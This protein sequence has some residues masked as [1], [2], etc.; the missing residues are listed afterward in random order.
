MSDDTRKDSEYDKTAGERLPEQRPHSIEKNKDEA[1]AQ[2]I[3]R[4]ITTSSNMNTRRRGV[5]ALFEHR[6]RDVWTYTPCTC[7]RSGCSGGCDVLA[8]KRLPKQRPQ[9]EEHPE[10]KIEVHLGAQFPHQDEEAGSIVFQSS[11]N[12]S[13]IKNDN[14]EARVMASAA[15]KVSEDLSNKDAEILRLIEERRSTPKKRSND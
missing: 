13:E 11:S 15:A 8:G 7:G 14:N 2:E 12:T 9:G 3:E 10:H 5:S 4:S 6:R 1:G